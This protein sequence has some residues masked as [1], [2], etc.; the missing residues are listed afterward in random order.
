MH[1]TT[2][3]KKDS[4]YQIII[5]YK[6]ASGKWRQKSKQGFAL[7]KDAK[8]VES[9]LLEEIKKQPR[10]VE[11]SM[12]GITLREFC[13]EVLKNKVS[14]AYGSKTC[15]LNAVKS[16]SK[17]ADQP[18]Q[19]IT[20]LDIQK[21]VREWNFN[22]PTQKQYRTKLD[23][24]F[25]AAVKP[26]G[27][28]ASNP[29]QDIEITKQRKKKQIKTL[30]AEAFQNLLK[31]LSKDT[32]I[33]VAVSIG[34]Y[35]GLRRAEIV[36]LT[37]D[38]IDFKNATLTVNKQLVPV[39][40]NIFKVEPYAKS[41]NGIRQLPL[42]L[43]LAKVLKEYYSSVPL[44]L[45]KALYGNPRKVYTRFYIAMKG[46]KTHPHALRHTYATKLLAENVDV[47]T[48]AALLG[49]NVETVI[50]NYIHYSD[51]MRSAAQSKVLKI[52]A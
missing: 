26:Y 37:W 47:Q 44:R 34:W 49:D 8:A 12:E 20:F 35:A 51:E 11:K 38:D 18:I 41:S 9:K 28:I 2:I 14:L 3:R 50:R 29:M 10:P 40:K 1:T 39:G 46:Y 17:L 45:D 30:T 27:L 52:F 31:G 36:A 4:G 32:E 19:S 15:Y 24:I 25:R 23:I 6:D 13:D 43:R 7:R 42:P 22:A 16:L 5:S 33:Y 21:V 48:V